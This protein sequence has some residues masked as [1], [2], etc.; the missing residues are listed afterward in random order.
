MTTPAIRAL[1]SMRPGRRMTL[2]TSSAGAAVA[3]LL[4]VVDDVL[5]YD[6]PWMK[7]TGGDVSPTGH[8]AT[9]ARLRAEGF[10]AAVVFTVYSQSALPA[11]L[12]CFEA[13]I[14]LRAAHCRENPYHLLTDWVREPEPERLARHEV[15]RQLDLVRTLGAATS[16]ERMTLAVPA[17]ARRA[18]RR[19][20]AAMGVAP[21]APWIAVHPGASAP[22]RRY[23]ADGFV[24]AGR[25]LATRGLPIVLVGATSEADVAGAIADGIG[26]S[27]RSMA[28]RTTIPELAALL[29]LAS[30]VLANNS[31]PMHLAAAVGTPVVALYALTNP[32]HTPWRVPSGVCGPDVPGPF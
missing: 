19:R 29:E 7:A 3:P 8:A 32:Q 11:A 18:M 6:P 23:P 1:A 4:P 31:G 14:P 13:G 2:L 30:V 28:G 9:I 27:A 26:P 20:L 25:V 17:D 10:D 22:S 5:V 24:R 15:R 21:D 16:D 12:L